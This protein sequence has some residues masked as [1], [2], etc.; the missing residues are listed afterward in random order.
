[1]SAEAG[2]SL[3]SGTETC[4]HTSGTAAGCAKALALG[5]A[6]VLTS[7]FRDRELSL[8]VQGNS[9]GAQLSKKLSRGLF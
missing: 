8:T 9:L 1:M 4:V 2:S 7:G 5:G 3:S 6:T